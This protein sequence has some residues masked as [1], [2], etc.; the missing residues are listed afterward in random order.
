MIPLVTLAD[1][2]DFLEAVLGT[3]D[4]DGSFLDIL[5]EEPLDSALGKLDDFERDLQ[6]LAGM[7]RAFDLPRRFPWLH[8]VQ[9]IA[10]STEKDITA[11]DGH[12][13]FHWEL[14]FAHIFRGP[15]GGFD[16]QVGNPPW[17]RPR[18]EENA[19]LAEHDPWFMLAERQT[20][21]AH[22][23]RRDTLME[24]PGVK[25][26]LLDEL[27]RHAGLAAALA[28]EQFHPLLRGTQPDLYRA[29]M[30]RTWQNAGTHGTIG[31]IHPDSHFSGEK[32]ALLREAAY[33]RLRLHG[34][35]VNA[36][37]RFFPPPV[38]RSSHFGVHIY[39]T[40]GEIGFDHLSWLFSV[41]ALRSSADHEEAGDPP[42]VRYRGDWDERPHPARIIHV[43]E[44]VL[45]EWQ[46][47]TGDHTLPP[48]RARLLSP[49]STAEAKAIRALARYPVRLGRFEPEIASGF[50]ESGAKKAGLIDYNV[51]DENGKIHTPANWSEVILKGPQ[52][53]LANP[54]F[55]QPS[56]GAGEVLG[57]NPM[58]L[59]EDALPE[60]PYRITTDTE[61]YLSSQERWR[62]SEDRKGV[63]GHHRK[64]SPEEKVSYT[65]F[66]RVAWRRQIAP[67]TERAL[68]VALIPPGAA[69][70]HMVHS[71]ALSSTELTAL[72]CGLWSSLP[73]DYLVRTTGRGDLQVQ[74]AKSLPA[75]PPE[76]P[77][78]TPL[79][80]RTLRLNSLTSAYADIW[81]ELWHEEMSRESWAV[82]WPHINGLESPSPQWDR[83]TPLRNE[84]ERRAALV[85]ID[86]LVAVWLGVSAEELTAM[87]KS[88][89]PIMQDFDAVTWFDA[90]GRKIAGNRYTYGF[91]QTKE[92]YEQL[93]AHF[94]GERSE[95]PE[96]YAGP[97]YKAEREKEMWA[98]HAV[99]SA[100]L[101]AAI[102]RGEWAPER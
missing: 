7:E 70:I 77:L 80:L 85:E 26:F 13:F 16:L 11:E 97:F 3:E 40:R 15:S 72:T 10:G 35:F 82:T 19:L 6:E 74:G 81:G 88:R 78:A 43:T 42:G 21:A 29:F 83:A 62:L 34:D 1:W 91:G 90:N 59:P 28:S 56:Q 92:H 36:G 61:T 45:A 95:P 41:D 86:A 66:Y 58:T 23:A 52:I 18:W 9:D 65:N 54:L 64:S 50:H 89:F 53:G 4:V 44:D 5:D 99:F 79:L 94:K 38:G 75:P 57:L 101:Q 63:G 22:T 39:G 46:R 96:G 73:V 68:Y 8:T 87:Y 20:R 14:H 49:V 37:N 33:E 84:M 47:L 51:P 69:H 17:V 100:R 30:C 67:D 25:T 32:E 12:G 71:M 48:S 60:T 31:L 2:L 55:K 27:A 93:Q 102:D 98:A 76:H 24:R